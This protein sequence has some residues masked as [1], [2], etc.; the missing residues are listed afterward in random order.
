MT[1]KNLCSGKEENVEIIGK[2]FYTNKKFFQIL[3]E[4]VKKV[5]FYFAL[6]VKE[7]KKIRLSD[8]EDLCI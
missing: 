6:I 4:V 5:K 3:S 1:L 8:K 7:M 2:D